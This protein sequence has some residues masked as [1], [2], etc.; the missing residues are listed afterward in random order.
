M[1]FDTGREAKETGLGNLGPSPWPVPNPPNPAPERISPA[2]SSAPPPSSVPSEQPETRYRQDQLETRYRQDGQWVELIE[3]YLA[4]L[5]EASLPEARSYLLRRVAEAFRDGLEDDAQALD[6]F[7]EAVRA[8]PMDSSF[9]PALEALAS[10]TQRWPEVLTAVSELV[11]AT[12]DDRVRAEVLVRLAGF[13]EHQFVRPQLA[14]PLLERALEIDPEHPSAIVA[15]ERCY[16]AMRAWADLVRC[17]QRRAQREALGGDCESYLQIGELFESQ[18]HDEAGAT[19]AYEHARAASPRD[20]RPIAELARLS[21]RANDWVAAS[22]YRE[23]LAAL[24]EDPRA[25]AQI[26]LAIG[27]MLAKAE[28]D[29]RRAQRHLERALVHDPANATAWQS[30]Q[31][32]ALRNNDW[33]K[34]AYCLEGRAAQTEGPRRKAQ[35]LVELATAREQMRDAAGALAAYESA[36]AADSSNELAAQALLGH[37]C[38]EARWADA[39]PLCEVLANAA[40]RDRDS[41][42]AFQLLRLATRIAF[43]LGNGERAVV[44]A[45]AALKLASDDVGAC[46]A[47]VHACHQVRDQPKVV[48]RA[49]EAL[50]RIAFEGQ[51]LSPASLAQ[52]GDLQV[53]LGEQGAAAET[54]LRAIASDPDSTLALAGLADIY[55]SRGQW[56]DAC[57]CT[58]QLAHALSEPGE[59]HDKLLIVADL[60]L[61]KAN[62]PDRAAQAFE[63]AL[64]LRPGDRSTLHALLAVYTAGERWQDVARVLRSL[65]DLD[66]KRTDLKAKTVYAM[67][68][69]VRDKV[70]DLVSAASLFEEALDLEPSR[71]EAFE[72]VVRIHTERRDWEGLSGAYVRMLERLPD[73]AEPQLRYQLYH[74]LGLV[75]R[76]RVGDGTAALAAFSAA[77]S[78][79]P[80]DT[81][82]RR[83]VTELYVVT[84]QLDKAIEETRSSLLLDPL[85][86][87]P[88]HELYALYL[89]QRAYDRAW[90]I[91]DALADLGGG[92]EEQA[93][94]LADY[95]PCEL[96]NVPGKLRPSAWATLL[97]HPRLDPT[98]TAVFALMTPAVVRARLQALSLK[99]QRAL[100]GEPLDVPRTAAEHG[101]LAGLHH[102][103]EILGH[104]APAVWRKA[105]P[106]PFAVGLSIPSSIVLSPEAVAA[107]APATLAFFAGKRVAE[108]RPALLARALYPSASE[109]TTILQAAIRLSGGHGAAESSRDV[110]SSR[111]DAL[112][113]VALGEAGLLELRRAAAPLAG[114]DGAPDAA[115]WS[116]VAD[117]TTTRAGLLLAGS[118]GVARRAMLL[119]NHYASDLAPRER[120]RE[121]LSFAVSDAYLELR[122][123]LGISVEAA[124]QP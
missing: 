39:A 88:Y 109:L 76:D 61:R 1:E 34:V 55:A 71:L 95:P 90:C 17:L 35:L 122:K 11:D 25:K 79:D 49:R 33:Q 32:L 108:Q 16:R 72:R 103:S 63:W 99:D 115:G 73:E 75:Y 113:T 28:R 96:M 80:D 87:G 23:Q 81:Q 50:E 86:P 2:G 40:T 94:F 27:E 107:L 124:M 5:E 114:R 105:G 41:E 37:Y 19:D 118:V 65:A 116:Q 98:L 54:Y 60:W 66:A 52:L 112:L 69:V 20:T 46:E 77:R 14:T 64:A 8:D 7:L 58:E 18:L 85:A 82:E 30:L 59:K 26:H 89:R 13:H 48:G 6:A 31:D 22:G 15:L 56:L 102:A 10:K 123:A 100:L 62:D 29:P 47:L 111:F 97:S 70:G 74:Q 101:G 117:L 51:P 78:I 12:T 68:Q 119:E 45:I 93:R 24:T 42:H 44:S 4:R 57:A 104:P 53:S 21:D 120:T 92:S 67:A 9:M 36:I 83:I 38:G 121:L 43:E 3:L 91:A 84:D 106:A 110:V